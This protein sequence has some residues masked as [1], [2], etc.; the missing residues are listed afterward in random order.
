VARNAAKSADAGE[1]LL[2]LAQA[3][4]LNGE[5]ATS[6]ATAKR[7]A[8]TLAGGLGEDHSMTRTARALAGS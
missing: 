7:A 6:I 3:Q 1:A 5:F 8:Q 2:L 4:R